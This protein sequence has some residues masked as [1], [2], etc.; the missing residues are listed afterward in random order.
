LRCKNPSPFKSFSPILF[1]A[2][3]KEDLSRDSKIQFENYDGEVHLLQ[4]EDDFINDLSSY[5]KRSKIVV[6]ALL[7]TGT[8]G[9]VQ[10]FYKK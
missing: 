4:N 3:K 6:D 2:A 7:G 10:G 1:L 9:E 5:L 8:K